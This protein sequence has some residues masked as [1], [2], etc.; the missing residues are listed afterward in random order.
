M[1]KF[2]ELVWEKPCKM[3]F[4]H[5]H[6]CTLAMRCGTLCSA[7]QGVDFHSIQSLIHINIPCCDI[8]FF[9]DYV[10]CPGLWLL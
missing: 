10:L 3:Q 2:G 1:E 4:Q 7:I 5:K 8:S 6:Y 9:D